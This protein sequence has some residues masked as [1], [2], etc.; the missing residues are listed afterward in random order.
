MLVV[1]VIVVA[2]V[3]AAYVFVPSFQ[4]GVTALAEDTSRILDSGMVGGIG[5]DR[6]GGTGGASVTPAT[7][8]TSPNPDSRNGITRLPSSASTSNSLAPVNPGLGI[9]QPP[10]ASAT[11][12]TVRPP[13]PATGT[14]QPNPGD[15]RS[16]DFVDF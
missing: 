13:N 6:G 16:G 9:P 11:S 8:G 12:G 7:I 4:N 14:M 10:P 3:A 5:L 1:S 2:V 15:P